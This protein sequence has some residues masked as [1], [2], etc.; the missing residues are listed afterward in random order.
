[1]S[2]SEYAK[3]WGEEPVMGERK[4]RKSSTHFKTGPRP[5]ALHM[6][7]SASPHLPNTPPELAAPKATQWST[8]HFPSQWTTRC[9]W[10]RISTGILRNAD[11]MSNVEA[12][13]PGG[14]PMMMFTTSGK[15]SPSTQKIRRINFGVN[16]LYRRMITREGKI[17]NDSKFTRG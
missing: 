6:H 13:E 14:S 7:T 17:L 16:R 3:A 12:S 2:S 15:K 5:Q 11:E 9:A 8:Q 4:N 10:S 1:M